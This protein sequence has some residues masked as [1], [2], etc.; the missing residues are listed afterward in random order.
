[1]KR[2]WNNVSL[3]WQ[4]RSPRERTLLRVTAGVVMLGVLVIFYDWQR[5]A[6]MRLDKQLPLAQIRL[7][8]MQRQAGEMNRLKSLPVSPRLHVAERIALLKSRAASQ[9]LDFTIRQVEETVLL[10]GE[11]VRLEKALAWLVEAQTD[12]RMKI[13]FLDVSGGQGVGDIQATF[14]DLPEG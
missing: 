5:S 4:G 8:V 9:Q 11:H 10:K 7:D 6:H 2:L 14:E 1:M 13:T 3:Y 12:L